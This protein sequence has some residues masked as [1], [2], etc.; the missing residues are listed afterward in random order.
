MIPLKFSKQLTFLANETILNVPK[1][2]L[3]FHGIDTFATILLNGLHVGETS[4]MFIK[5]TFDVTK[6]LKVSNIF[7]Y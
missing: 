7:L 1:V 4:N 5:Y 3:I 2:A 6:Y